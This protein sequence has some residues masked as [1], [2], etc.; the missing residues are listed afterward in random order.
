MCTFRNY[1]FCTVNHYQNIWTSHCGRLLFL[2]RHCGTKK[3]D[4]DNEMLWLSHNNLELAR[5]YTDQKN[6]R[7]P[8]LYSSLETKHIVFKI[9]MRICLQIYQQCGIMYLET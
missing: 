4:N 7:P 6:I 1:D 8:L 9:Y 5:I 3:Q 2:C